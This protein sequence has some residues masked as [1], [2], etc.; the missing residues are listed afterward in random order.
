MKEQFL[1]VMWE[2]WGKG[3]DHMRSNVMYTAAPVP[4]MTTKGSTH[5]WGHRGAQSQAVGD[6]S[7]REESWKEDF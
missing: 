6:E 4:S 2:G 7:G 1:N 3:G 5:S